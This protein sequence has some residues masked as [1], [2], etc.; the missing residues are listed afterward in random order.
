[1]AVIHQDHCPGCHSTNLSELFRCQDHTVSKEHF[2]VWAC[3]DC[4]GRFTQDVPDEDSIGAY[5][6]SED[7]ISHSNTSRGLINR[8]YQMVRTYTVK[9]KVELIRRESGKKTGSLLDV[10]CG[11]GQFLAG[12]KA[13]G[14]KV[15]GL[16]PDPGARKLA[17]E[18]TGET[19]EAP[20]ALFA[21]RPVVDVISLWHVLEHVH[22]LHEYLDQFQYL[23]KPDG[24]LLI[25]VPNFTS[26]DASHYG[27]HWAAYDVPRHLYHFS[28]D[29]LAVLM[30]QH[31]FRI[32]RHLPMPFDAFYVSMLSEQIKHG[33]PRLVAAFLNGLRSWWT[34]RVEVSKGSSVLY[35]IRKTEAGA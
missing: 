9:K 13:A 34:S 1:M 3:A 31:G 26:R 35:V 7:Y 5:Y 19:I 12:M 28:P 27:A 15:S 23:L 22:R 30:S 6:Q 16:E 20:E 32:E 11:T 17:S 29:S 4:G 18:V 25:A 10:G 33:K 21:D 14:W 24:L 2:A 8:I